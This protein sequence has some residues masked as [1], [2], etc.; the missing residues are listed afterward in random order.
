[1][2]SVKGFHSVF[3][4]CSEIDSAKS[5]DVKMVVLVFGL[6]HDVIAVWLKFVG[7]L[8]QLNSIP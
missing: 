5:G 3:V 4:G 8:S 2:R 1:M 6:R 7:R